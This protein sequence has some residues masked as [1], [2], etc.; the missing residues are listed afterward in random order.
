LDGGTGSARNPA[1][2]TRYV[3]DG[4][5]VAPDDTSLNVRSAWFIDLVT[6]TPRFVTAHPLPKT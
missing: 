4:P 6:Q 1:Y 2:I 3:I 5:L